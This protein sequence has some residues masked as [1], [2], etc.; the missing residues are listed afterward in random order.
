M[1]RQDRLVSWRHS[2]IPR[3]AEA[4]GAPSELLGG[5]WD[6]DDYSTLGVID[7]PANGPQTARRLTMPF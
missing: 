2:D 5:D 1:A 6:E 3:F 4:L 7:V